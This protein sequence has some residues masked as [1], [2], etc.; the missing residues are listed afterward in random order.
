MY[1]L[2]V[3]EEGESTTKRKEEEERA[4]ERSDK[5][6]TILIILINLSSSFAFSMLFDKHWNSNNRSAANLWPAIEERELLVDDADES[7][8]RQ[9][10]SR[11]EEAEGG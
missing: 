6:L 9:L 1:L 4:K 5:N 3:V 11:N 10:F 2:P 8:C 7:S